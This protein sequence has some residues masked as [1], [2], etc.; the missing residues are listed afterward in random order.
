MNILEIYEQA[1][2]CIKYI[3]AEMKK[4]CKMCE[5]ARTIEMSNKLYYHFLSKAKREVFAT[6]NTMDKPYIIYHVNK[7]WSY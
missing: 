4:T 1:D 3:R 7:Y 2:A 5:N 6:I